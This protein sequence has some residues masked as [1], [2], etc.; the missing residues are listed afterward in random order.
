MYMHMCIY[1]YI[2]IYSIYYVCMYSNT[3]MYTHSV[4]MLQRQAR[5][6]RVRVRVC[7]RPISLLT[8]SLLTLLDSNFPGNPL[9]TWE[10]HPLNL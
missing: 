10:F 9:W 7:V 8:L 3:H 5:G 6:A 4:Y 2:Y 1:T